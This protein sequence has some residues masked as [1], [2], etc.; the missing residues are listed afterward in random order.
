M[1]NVSSPQRAGFMHEGL[2][3]SPGNTIAAAGEGDEESSANGVHRQ[4][5]QHGQPSPLPDGQLHHHHIHDRRLGGTS[6]VQDPN[7]QVIRKGILY[8]LE[9]HIITI[10][11]NTKSFIQT[12]SKVSDGVEGRGLA[13]AMASSSGAIVLAAAAAAAAGGGSAAAGGAGAPSDDDDDGGGGG[14]VV[15]PDEVG[16]SCMVLM[17]EDSMSAWLDGAARHGADEVRVYGP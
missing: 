3:T 2:M 4:H 5:Q 8:L 15:S 14:G 17:A 12:M 9:N 7:G 11:V 10:I 13:S 16:D 6:S 1:G